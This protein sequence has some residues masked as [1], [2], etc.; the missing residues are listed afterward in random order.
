MRRGEKRRSCE[1]SQVR[2]GG[3]VGHGEF[4][5]E[6][7]WREERKKDGVRQGEM[8]KTGWHLAGLCTRDSSVPILRDKD[9]EFFE[10]AKWSGT[11]RRMEMQKGS[12]SHSAAGSTLN[13]DTRGAKGGRRAPDRRLPFPFP[14]PLLSR[15]MPSRERGERDVE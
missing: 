2:F 4:G 13:E 8:L 5:S 15:F 9:G 14:F 1:S 10:I 11:G 7:A 6:R 12:V 3:R